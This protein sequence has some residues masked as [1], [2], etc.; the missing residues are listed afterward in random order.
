MPILNMIYWA[1]W[2]GG[3]WKPWANTLI[4]YDFET[5][6]WSN[7]PNLWTLGSTYDWVATW[8]TF[9][10]LTSWKKVANYT[11]NTRTN[12][13]VTSATMNA[14]SEFTIA[15]WIN[16]PSSNTGRTGCFGWSSSSAELDIQFN[17]VGKI[18]TF[19]YNNGWIWE[20]KNN[21]TVLDG[22]WH[23]ICWTYDST[24]KYIISLDNSNLAFTNVEWNINNAPNVNWFNVKVWKTGNNSFDWSWIG[25]VWC[26]IIEDK[27]RTAQEKLDYFNQTKWDYWIS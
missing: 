20:W 6:N 21:T 9:S 13:I 19:V 18:D 26:F 3:W 7:V 8:V 1:T 12:G 16:W 23:F 22:N 5:A 17:A 4:Y 24:N 2:W 15:F 27:A 11:S 14:P 10:T 25:Q